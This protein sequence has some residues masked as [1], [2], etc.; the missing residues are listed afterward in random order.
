MKKT[1]L[2][3]LDGKLDVLIEKVSS[4]DGRLGR[5][6]D[7]LGCVEDRLGRVEEQVAAL[8]RATKEG[9]EKLLPESQ[10]PNLRELA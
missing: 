9:F 4:L 8:T 1:T 2:E 5:V 10:R 3:D 6:E 7:R